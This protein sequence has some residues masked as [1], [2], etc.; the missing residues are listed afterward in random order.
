MKDYL[1]RVAIYRS[2]L[3]G[4]VLLCYFLQ[5]S[6][7][8]DYVIFIILIVLL[9]GIFSL[10]HVEVMSREVHIRKHYFWGLIGCKWVLDFRQ[11]TRL[12]TKEYEIDTLEESAILPDVLY[13]LL[14]VDALRPKARW[15]TTKLYYLDNETEKD[16]ELKMSRDDYRE[17][18][19]KVKPRDDLYARFR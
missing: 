19:R 3:L 4:I 12:K 11:I 16:I 13:T 15:L 14:T 8:T 7:L 1:K 2:I 18:D 17:I 9:L 5:K 10:S 6:G